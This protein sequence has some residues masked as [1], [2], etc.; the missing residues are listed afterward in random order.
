[1]G[2]ASVGKVK[3]YQSDW[4]ERFYLRVSV[5]KKSCYREGDLSGKIKLDQKGICR[6]RKSKKHI[7]P[8]GRLVSES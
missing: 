1:M 7:E 6:G 5:G 3:A 8:S 2:G 4:G